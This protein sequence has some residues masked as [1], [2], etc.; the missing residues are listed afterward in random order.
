MWVFARDGL[1]SI[2]QQRDDPS[3]L[4]VRGRVKG[5][6]ERYFPKANVICTP[7]GDYLYRTT[8]YR[9]EVGVAIARIVGDINYDKFKPAVTDKRREMAYL[10]CFMALEDMQYDLS[11]ENG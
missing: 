3:K 11:Q 8:V 2:V 9:D 10:E 6:I 7:D 4:M 5:D 1:L